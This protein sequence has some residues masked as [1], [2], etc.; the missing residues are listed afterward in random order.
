V[1][2]RVFL[3]LTNIQKLVNLATRIYESKPSNY[4]SLITKVGPLQMRNCIN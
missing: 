1:D 4:I 3:E 2:N